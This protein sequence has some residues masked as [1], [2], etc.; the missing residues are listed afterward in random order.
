MEF[1]ETWTVRSTEPYGDIVEFNPPEGEKTLRQVA[2]GR[3]QPISSA[4]FSDFNKFV[5]SY[6]RDTTAVGDR[7]LS[8]T[9]MVVDGHPAVRLTYEN[10]LLQGMLPR[11]VVDFLIGVSDTP[12]GIVY[13][14]FYITDKSRAA[15]RNDDAVYRRMLA[16]LRIHQ[17]R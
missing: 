10:R 6:E 11:I 9:A 16:S 12:E 13:R 15:G 17:L 3:V 8:R 7:L 2:F 5:R 14:F 1:P 4:W